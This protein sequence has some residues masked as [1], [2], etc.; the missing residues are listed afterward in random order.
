MSAEENRDPASGDE[1]SANAAFL[2]EMKDM[3]DFI[4]RRIE[5]DWG[6]ALDALEIHV[7]GCMH[8]GMD[9]QRRSWSTRGT[10]T[11]CCSAR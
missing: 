5:E 4:V 10:C 3:R 6:P 8:A 7:G 2:S 1:A 9:F 11:T